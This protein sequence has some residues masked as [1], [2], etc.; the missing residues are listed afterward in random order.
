M[1]TLTLLSDNDSWPTNSP[2]IGLGLISASLSRVLTH[3]WGIQQV[4]LQSFRR[5][6]DF[7]GVLK[8]LWVKL[9]SKSDLMQ[10]VKPQH[11]TVGMPFLSLKQQHQNT[12]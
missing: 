6:I 12:G 3:A 2:N 9:H 1:P 10:I 4:E 5:K 8:L 7:W 11:F